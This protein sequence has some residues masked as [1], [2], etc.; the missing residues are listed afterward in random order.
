[1][2]FGG[3]WKVVEGSHWM[4]D[5]GSSKAEADRTVEIIKHYKLGSMCFVGRRTCG[6]V[7]P[8]THASTD[9]AFHSPPK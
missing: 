1:M 4:I 9:C 2:K 6:D 5:T 7:T 8:N 3:R